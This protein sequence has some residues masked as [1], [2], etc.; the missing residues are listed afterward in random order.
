MPRDHS[1]DPY[2]DRPGAVVFYSGISLL[3]FDGITLALRVLAADILTVLRPGVPISFPFMNIMQGTL[4]ICGG[5]LIVVGGWHYFHISG[6]G[7]QETKEDAD[8]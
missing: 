2:I 6:E 8:H 3:F 5:L 4:A 1:S 7:G